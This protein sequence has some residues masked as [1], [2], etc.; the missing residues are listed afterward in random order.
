MNAFDKV[1]HDSVMSRL[2][3]Y[4]LPD[5]SP[6]Y[7]I[8]LTWYL[9]TGFVGVSLHLAGNQ[10]L[11]SLFSDV[12]HARGQEIRAQPA[13]LKS[14]KGKSKLLRQTFSQQ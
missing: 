2:L 9:R 6:G 4:E 5:A 14:L 1:P 3:K 7:Q 13:P 10:F 11:R 12:H 8:N